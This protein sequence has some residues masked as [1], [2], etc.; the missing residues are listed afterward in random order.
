MYNCKVY[1]NFLLK[2]THIYLKTDIFFYFCSFYSR[3]LIAMFLILKVLILAWC[4]T[5]SIQ[6]IL[7]LA[8]DSSILKLI[9]HYVPIV[10]IIHKLVVWRISGV[11]TV[12]NAV[13]RLATKHGKVL[14]FFIELLH[15]VE[16]TMALWLHHL[17]VLPVSH[18]SSWWCHNFLTVLGLIVVS[19]HTHLF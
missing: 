4:I 15:V 18:T 8:A 12:L 6:I 10:S 1:I 19:V 7:I 17:L 3:S 2:T 11:L 5:F 13:V 9:C 14:L 16:H